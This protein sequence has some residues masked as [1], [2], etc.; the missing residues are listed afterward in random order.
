MCYNKRTM[1][2][3]YRYV[4]PV[5]LTLALAPLAASAITLLPPC[6]TGE[7]NCGITDLLSVFIN[8]A[9]YLLGISGAVALG[10]FVYGGFVYVL[11][12]GKPEEVKKATSILTNAVIGI[13]I[14]FLSGV[15]VRYTTQALTGGQSL[16]PTVGES[17]NSKTQ[18]SDLKGDGLWV[19][20]PAGT[21]SDGSSIPESLYCVAKE[22]SAVKGGDPCENLNKVLTDRNL[23]DLA[24]YTCVD[25]GTA[26]RCVRGLCSQLPANYA[27][28]LK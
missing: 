3:S 14:I 9:E 12:R 11:S 2:R 24:N 22:K 18:K 1:K 26:S 23:P 28:C 7:G 19:T 5:L 13:A 6:A 20:I 15:L 8:V 25:V 17:C 4:L 10:F 16:I 21:K 27:C